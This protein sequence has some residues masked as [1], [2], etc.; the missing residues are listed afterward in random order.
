MPLSF[1][2]NEPSFRRFFSFAHASAAETARWVACFQHVLRKLSLRCGGKRLLLKCDGRRGSDTRAR[3]VR[4]ASR[5][6]H[7]RPGAGSRRLGRSP[8]HTARVRL[9]LQLY[10]DAQFVYIHRHPCAVYQSACHMADTQYWH[11]YFKQPTDEQASRPPRPA[12]RTVPST[13]QRETK[14]ERKHWRCSARRDTCAA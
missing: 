7:A 10:P 9:L 1:M 3:A 11:M 12:P 8:V 2:T 5:A 4:R 6:P 13:E 14:T